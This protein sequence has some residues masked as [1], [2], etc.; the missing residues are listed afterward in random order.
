MPALNFK[1]INRADKGSSNGLQD[2]FELFARDFLRACGLTI[3]EDPS[4]GSDGGKDLIVE[5]RR[6][7]RMGTNTVRWLVSCKH[8]AHSNDS[9]GAADELDLQ[10]RLQK[11]SCRGFMAVYS[12]LPSGGLRDNFNWLQSQGYEVNVLDAER[13]ETELL[14][15]P[16]M[17]AIARRYFPLSMEALEKQ[18]RPFIKA[19]IDN[20]D[21]TALALL[22]DQR[23][24]DFRTL[25]DV[26]ADQ[27]IQL[28]V[29][30]YV[31][32]ELFA[33]TKGAQAGKD[34]FHRKRDVVKRLGI[35]QHP[36]PS[37]MVARDLFNIVPDS[38]ESFSSFSYRFRENEVRAFVSFVLNKYRK[39]YK[40]ELFAKE[41]ARLFGSTQEEEC[42]LLHALTRA[43]AAKPD[44]RPGNVEAAV[45]MDLVSTYEATEQ[46]A[47]MMIQK[48]VEDFESN[49]AK[50]YS[51]LQVDSL[52]NSSRHR[53]RLEAMS[54]KTSFD[55][56][57]HAILTD[58]AA[59]WQMQFKP[60]T[61]A[62]L[63]VK[64]PHIRALLSFFYGAKNGFR[65]NKV[66]ASNPKQHRAEMLKQS[67]AMTQL[68][69]APDCDVFSTSAEYVSRLQQGVQG[70]TKIRFGRNFWE[71]VL[72]KVT[73][74][75]GVPYDALAVSLGRCYE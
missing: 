73:E 40:L 8:K 72:T 64:L 54:K 24:L 48:S 15:S 26:L 49:K 22:K 63:K 29:S 7:G 27:D 41:A 10:M 65:V 16:E 69:Y 58:V 31:W 68:L 4:R 36:R 51:S 71:T 62:D 1:E 21:L 5:E 66:S 2:S 53:N 75:T 23:P 45:L 60:T 39:G 30:P 25:C 42:Q 57:A 44:A 50:M 18:G 67:Y 6:E 17:Q 70:L 19:H 74:K 56:E 13:L 32:A 3:V 20:H 61:P 38:S 28:F 52:P 46:L 33:E 37:E 12:T 47:L 14:A 59:Q 43:A 34:R 55:A 9:V 11:F 35:Q